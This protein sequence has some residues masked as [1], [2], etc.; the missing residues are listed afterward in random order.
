MNGARYDREQTAEGRI[1][2]RVME[3]FHAMEKRNPSKG[4]HFAMDYAD[5]RQYLKPY[6]EREMVVTQ[7]EETR[8]HESDLLRKLAVVE[9]TIIGRQTGEVR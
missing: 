2:A 1:A 6:L 3:L 4:G 9:A 7:L 8:K 5:L